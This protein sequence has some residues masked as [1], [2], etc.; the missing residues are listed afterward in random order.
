M[1]ASAASSS[2]QAGRPSR[3]PGGSPERR[4]LLSRFSDSAPLRFLRRTIRDRQ[5]L[6]RSEEGVRA[7]TISRR[8][9][10]VALTLIGGTA[11]WALMATTALVDRQI[12]LVDHRQG[13]QEMEIG[14]AEL[15]ADL[16]LRHGSLESVSDR[17]VQHERLTQT[18]LARN[19]E[20]LAEIADLS[21]ALGRSEAVRDTLATSRALLAVEGLAARERLE[22]LAQ[23][24]RAVETELAGLTGALEGRRAAAGNVEEEVAVLQQA[25]ALR[26]D[27][28]E[29]ADRFA[30]ALETQVNELNRALSTVFAAVDQ[31]M[32][33]RDSLRDAVLQQQQVLGENSLE[34]AEKDR[35]L[36]SAWARLAATGT[37]RDRLMTEQGRLLAELERAGRR[38]RAGLAE[39]GALQALLAQAYHRTAALT[40]ER[41]A[42]LDDKGD[43]SARADRLDRELQRLRQ[44]QGQI[45]AELRGRADDHVGGMQQGLAHTGL[46][47][48]DLLGRLRD[49]VGRDTGGPMVPVLPSGAPGADEAWD[50][51]MEV[52]LLLGR[53]AELSNLIERLPVAVPVRDTHRI[54]SAFGR[55]SDP[56]T[57]RA[58]YHMGID[59]AAPRRTEIFS[60]APGRVVHAGRQG[61]YGN[62]VEIDHGWGIRSRYAHL[63]SVNVR[64][65]QRVER[66]ESIGLLGCTGRC[67]GPHLHYEI[68]VNGQQ[69]D[70]ANFIRAGRHVFELQ[71]QQATA[72]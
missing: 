68:L 18:L 9:Q 6:L 35:L 19:Q 52:A 24:R 28:L 51:A 3:S 50:E 46:N 20:A 14:Y 17:L 47:I 12:R 41:D 11:L 26:D 43:L 62:L 13:L 31:L 54:S 5:L 72:N 71:Q 64:A 59:F 65:N 56:F 69:R 39:R 42:L 7:L 10:I 40:A 8:S 34:L 57:G 32:L 44:S 37:E 36:E 1:T 48:D 67:T 4:S 30:A 38:D 63:H 21:A 45:L 16:A 29:S 53:A 15:I 61:A 60:A 25:M 66:G 22:R 70:P 49:E 58:A 33:E 23:E 55:R 2:R 27:A